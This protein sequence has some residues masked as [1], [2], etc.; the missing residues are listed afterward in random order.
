MEETGTV[1]TQEIAGTAPAG[2]RV[3]VFYRAPADDPA[4]VE[5]VYREVSG[6]L[7]GT[8]GLLG[9]QL[10]KDLTDPGSYVVASDWVDMAAFGLWDKST[11]HRKTTPLDPYQDADPQRRRHFGIYEVVA[12][13]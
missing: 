5:R 12:S 8:V 11:G 4:A 1:I 3:L 6:H 7:R 13:Y 9:N 2:A 10:L